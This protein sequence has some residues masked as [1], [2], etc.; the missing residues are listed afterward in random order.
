MVQL[1]LDKVS[2]GVVFTLDQEVLLELNR[3]G[4]VPYQ[5]NY[6]FFTPEIY[7][8]F[9]DANYLAEISIMGWCAFAILVRLEGVLTR[10][11]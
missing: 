8:V 5:Y 3:V 1:T 6:F 2:P 7:F 11:R 4:E 9:T 10:C